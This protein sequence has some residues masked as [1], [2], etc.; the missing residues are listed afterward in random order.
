MSVV[1]VV[2][3]QVE[4]SVTSW[5][6]V[7]RIPTECDASACDRE[8]S[9]MWRLWST[10]GLLRHG[11]KYEYIYKKILSSCVICMH[12]FALSFVFIVLLEQ[13]RLN[14]GLLYL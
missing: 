10:K 7:Q 13:G 4:V 14:E 8:A 6:L 12:T 2:F 11:K 5:S 3:C 1:S 9:V